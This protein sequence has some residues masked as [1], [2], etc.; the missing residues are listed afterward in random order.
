MDPKQP[1]R[2]TAAQ[3]KMKAAFQL[4]KPQADFMSCILSALFAALPAFIA[5]MMECLG[6]GNTPG[7]DDYNPGN[8]DRC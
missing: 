2:N 6:G 7:A 4:T 8:R 3:A 1:T 5:A